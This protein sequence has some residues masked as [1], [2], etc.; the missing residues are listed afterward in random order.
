MKKLIPYWVEDGNG[1]KAE[2]YVTHEV[3]EVL[4]DGR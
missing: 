1:N 4:D 2:V 3:F